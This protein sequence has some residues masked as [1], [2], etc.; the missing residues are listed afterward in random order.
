MSLP[1]TCAGCCH[2]FTAD[3]LW[4]ALC[5]ECQLPVTSLGEK[6]L[7]GDPVR[8]RWLPGVFPKG[9]VTVDQGPLFQHQPKE[10][11]G[12]QRGKPQLKPGEIYVGVTLR[13]RLHH[14]ILLPGSTKSG[15]VAAKQWAREQGGVL[16]S[17][18]DGLVLFKYARAQFEAEPYWTNELTDDE[19]QRHAVHQH[20]GSGS[21][22]SYHV[23]YS[24]R[25]RAVRIVQVEL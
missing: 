3:S 22:Y 21:Q 10:A 12:V 9:M 6:A 7:R 13:D 18:H 25:A 11:Q 19:T 15:W 2:V 5:P 14:L 23:D 24:I 4:E 20:F 17:R 1:A 16:P 8:S